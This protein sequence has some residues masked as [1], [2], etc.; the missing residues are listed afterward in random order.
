M[1]KVLQYSAGKIVGHRRC[2]ETGSIDRSIGRLMP[3]S[4][5]PARAIRCRKRCVNNAPSL[6]HYMIPART[7]HQTL[8]S[9]V[10][11]CSRPSPKTIGSLIATNCVENHALRVLWW[12]LE[13][14]DHMCYKI[15]QLIWCLGKICER[16]GV[17]G[18]KL[19][20]HSAALILASG[21]FWYLHQ[22]T[23]IHCHLDRYCKIQ[24]SKIRWSN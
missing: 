1:K 24:L 10:L 11:C 19:I 12:T 7:P 17:Q 6:I 16:G 13:R 21:R 4:W 5:V 15:I 14:A 20:R 8:L 2:S 3:I 18:V 22:C 23:S 9:K